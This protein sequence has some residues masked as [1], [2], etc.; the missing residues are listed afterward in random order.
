MWALGNQQ[1]IEMIKLLLIQ[2]DLNAVD[3][4]GESCF[5]YAIYW[6]EKEV[7]ANTE[8]LELLLKDKGRYSCLETLAEDGYNAFHVATMYSQV[9][10]C[11]CLLEAGC[12]VNMRSAEDCTALHLAVETDF[13]RCSAEDLADFLLQAGADIDA[14]NYMGS[15]PLHRAISRAHSRSTLKTVT[16]KLLVSNCDVNIPGRWNIADTVQVPWEVCIENNPDVTVLFMLLVAGSNF[17][18]PTVE[19]FLQTEISQRPDTAKNKPGFLTFNEIVEQIR[20]LTSMPRTL[21]LQCRIK[22]RRLLGKNILHKLDSLELP[23]E[24]KDFLAL[25]E[26]FQLDMG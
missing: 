5:H 23:V 1:D 17:Y 16:R 18:R 22:L 13:H 24:L 3:D 2:S 6:A 9:K 11:E 25:K 19:R 14:Q 7:P 10:S 12:S 8:A 15:T 26:F 4:L 20:Y 21:K